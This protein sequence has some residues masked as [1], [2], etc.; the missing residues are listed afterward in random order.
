MYFLGLD[1][2]ISSTLWL[3]A[4]SIFIF[5]FRK[6]IKKLFYKRASLDLFISRLKSYLEKTHPYIKFDFTIIETSQTEENPELRKQIIV[7]EIL[8]QFK[9]IELDKDKYPRST[10]K[11]LQWSGYVFNCEPN[12]DKLPPDWIQRKN[13]LYVRDKKKCFRC[14]TQVDLKSLQPKLIRSLKD[15]GKYHLEN[16]IPLCFD[17]MK[18][19]SDDPKKSSFLHI[20][21]TLYDIVK[22]S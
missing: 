9:S 15:G 2:I 19:T 5:A 1:Y 18:I 17:C 3:I 6:Q 7:D 21:D 10:P 14:G 20:Q 4:I 22:N 13:A 8:Y 16:M 11:E 12:K